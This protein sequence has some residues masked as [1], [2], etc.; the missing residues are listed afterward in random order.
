MRKPTPERTACAMT[1]F[2]NEVS[3]MEAELESLELLEPEEL[4]E[5]EE[6]DW[7]RSRD[8]TPWKRLRW[9]TFNSR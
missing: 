9:I 6:R 2:C 1:F 7:V 4:L 3:G 8:S 5:D